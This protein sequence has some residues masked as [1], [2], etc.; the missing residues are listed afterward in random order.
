[1]SDM[2]PMLIEVDAKES[3]SKT[4]GK[5]IGALAAAQLEYDTATKD[6][7]NPVYSEGARKSRY[8]DLSTIIGAT[9]K[10][11]ARQGL[12][13]IQTPIIDLPNQKAGVLT[14]LAH[15]SDEWISN[16]LILPAVMQ[17]KAIWE[18]GVKTPGPPRFDTQSVGSAITYARRYAYQA[19]VG[20]AAEVDDDGNAASGV[21]KGSKEEAQAVG[22]QRVAEYSEKLKGQAAGKVVEIYRGK[23]GNLNAWCFVKSEALA[24]LLDNGGGPLTAFA[25]SSRYVMEEQLEKVH[26]VAAGLN[27]S[28]KEVSA[29]D[30]AKKPAEASQEAGNAGKVAS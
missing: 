27:M 25:G 20:I 18:N 14:L 29:P 24:L 1:M 2:E 11:L 7:E 12:A 28:L 6:S 10:A 23:V 15:S 8:A 21:D 9:Q 5:L 19:I 16:E 30:S 26:D 3:R 17:G 22:K 13:V 4:I